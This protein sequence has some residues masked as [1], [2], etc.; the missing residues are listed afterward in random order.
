MRMIQRSI[1]YSWQSDTEQSVNRFLIRDALKA[2]AKRLSIPCEVDEA[3]RGVAGSPPIFETILRKI[4][5]SA[6]FVGDVTIVTGSAG[7]ASCN[8]NVLIEYGFALAKLGENRLVP[9]LNSHFG[10]PERLPFDLRHR[11][12]RVSYNLA[13]DASKDKIKAA[14]KSLVGLLF[15]ELRL[16]LE[17]PKSVFSLSESQGRIVQYLSGASQRGTGR[18]YYSMEEISNGTGIEVEEVKR[19]VAELVSR[20]YL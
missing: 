20:Y 18:S 15:S 5:Q 1:F 10:T 19:A 14:Q 16:L 17:D 4:E 13:P 6:V 7:R 12:V 11:A 8:P 2:A 9:V 3:T